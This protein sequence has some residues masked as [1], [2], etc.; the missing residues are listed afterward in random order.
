[1]RAFWR[2]FRGSKQR[3]Y[4]FVAV[5]AQLVQNAETLIAAMGR[6]PSFHDANVLTVTRDAEDIAISIHLF[7][8]TDQVDSARYYILDKHHRVEIV[9]RDVLSNSLPA[10]YVSDCLSDLA[11]HRLSEFIRVEFES[12]TDQC[13]VV[14]CR[15]VEIVSVQACLP[16]GLPSFR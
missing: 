9:M 6:W 8:M 5:I 1:L 15:S 11:F 16:K 10:G 13:G 14:V 2:I 4:E 12:H 3:I 7:A